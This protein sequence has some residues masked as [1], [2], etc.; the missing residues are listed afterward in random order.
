MRFRG[1]SIRRKIVAL[2][3]VPLVSLTG[4]WVFATYITGRQADELMSAGSIVEKV[5]EPLED[6]V[7][8]VQD[9]RRQ[10]LVFLADPRASDA[11]PVLMGQRAATDRI[12]GEVREN[13]RE[14]DVRDSL[15]AADSSRLDAIL[16]AV[17]GLEALRESVEKRTIS[18]AKA[19]DFY[20]GLVDPSYR[21]LNGLHTLQNVSMDKQMRALV[22]ISRAR[23]M[24]SRQDALIASGLI[25]GRFTTAELRQISGLVAQRELLYEGSL[26]NL[27]AAERR[28]V[29]QFWGSPDTEPLRTAEDALIEAGPTKR[30]GAVDADRWEEAAVPVLDRLAGDST[31]MGNR[32]QDRAEP[33]AYRVLAQAGIA[34]I[35][36]FLALIVSIFVS[37]RI[38]RELVRDLS[39][40]RKDAH[41]V[42]GVRLPSV[43]RRLAAG[44]Q[45]DVETEA[46]HLSYEPDEIGQVGQALNTLQRAAVEAAVKQADMR[47]GVSEVFVNLARRNQVLLHRQLTLLDAMERRTENSD[48]L[49][50]LFRLDHLTTRMRRHAEGLVILSGAAPSRQWRKPIQLMDVVR[51]AVAEV[52]DYERI[53]VRRLARIGVGGPAVA[54]LTHLIAELLENATVFSPPHTAVQVHGERVSNGFTLEIHDRG[55]GMAPEVLLDANLRLAETPDFELSDTDRLGL[56]VVSRLAQRQ[57]VRVSLQKSPYGGTTAVVFIPAALLTDAPDTHGTGFRLDRR[58]E[59][60]IGSGRSP[61]AAPGAPGTAPGGERRVNGRSA[62]LSPVPT[63]LTGP[64]VLDGPV[65]LEAPVGPLDFAGDPL[66]R[67]PDPA[68]DPALGPV[69]DGVSDLEDTESERGGIFRARDVRRDGDREPRRD[70]PGGRPRRNTDRDQHQQARDHGDEPTA[71]VRPMRPAGPVPLPR[72]TPPTLVTDRGRRVDAADDDATTPPAKATGPVPHTADR[73][74]EEAAGPRTADA[75]WTVRA[76]AHRGAP[77]ISRTPDVARTS[78]AFRTSDAS[79][80]T[81][82]SRSSEPSHAPGPSHAPQPPRA[83][84]SGRAEAPVPAAPPAP[85]TIGGLPRRV[86]QA[87]LARQLREDSAE[88]TVQRAPVDT[89]DDGERDADEVRNRMASLQRGWQRGR[90][91]N[92]E[93]T[94]NAASTGTTGNTASTTTTE[95][96]EDTANTGDPGGTAPGTTPGGDGR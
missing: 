16:S 13:A 80:T 92:A 73:A 7:R 54:D 93:T 5:S 77:G 19:L 46:P 37:V 4:L 52:E 49:A 75:P 53:E 41:E 70:K 85:D 71:E 28:R 14:Q 87:S 9:E 62:V 22:G 69:L 84:E 94:E 24:L 2:L 15:S 58:A 44:E 42:S 10:T 32:F 76:A 78:E 91:E 90:R 95:S 30:P 26:E 38:G 88:R 96:A 64:G 65:E 45:V 63:G 43:M 51:A 1:K 50:D 39:R 61:E 66:D 12:V 20:N 23:E 67:S 68:L 74:P 60:A 27:P 3:L 25:A 47:R 79:R 82:P 29:E 18:R 48:E 33:A 6:A 86:R 72:R 21:F 17:D 40:L 31:E 56:F 59:R 11:L 35:L 89:F 36:G 57:N 8:A 34:G 55:L 83:P 81:G